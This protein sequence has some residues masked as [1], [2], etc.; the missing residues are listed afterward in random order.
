MVQP[1]NAKNCAA[2]IIKILENHGVTHVFGVPGAKIDSLFIA[3]KHSKI[4]LVLCRHEQNAAFMA[5]AFGRLTGT[6]GVCIATSGPG[7]TNLTTGLATATSEGDPVLAIGGEVPLDE[8]LKKT[9]QSL[10]AVDLMK[11]VTKFSAEVVTAHQL[12]EIIGNAI[13]V[14]ES[15]RPGAVFV[16]LPKDVGLSDFDGDATA[17]WGKKIPQGPC[18]DLAI[19]DAAKALHASKRPIAI[20][21][22][23]SSSKTCSEALIE[24]LKKTQIPYISTFQG[25]G[26]WV[27]KQ[28]ASIYAGRIGLFRNQ[29]ADKLLEQADL[30]ITIGYDAIEYDPAIWNANNTRPMICIDTIRADQDNSFIPTAEL[31]GDIGH[32]LTL[33]SDAVSINMIDIDSDYIAAAQQAFQ[34]VQSTIAEGKAMDNFP[35]QPLRLV[36]ELQ[37]QMTDATHVALDVGSNYIWTNRYGVTHHAR[38]VLVSNGQ[39]TLGVSVPWAI[40]LSLLYPDQRVLSVSGDGGFLF[41]SMELETAVRVGAKF[42]HVIWDSHS[43]DMVAFQEMA[44]YGE[45]AGVEL[46]GYDVVKMAESFGCKGYSIKSAN[47][48]PHVFEEAFK[49]EVP[50]LI[51]VPVDYSLNA[52]LMEDIHQSFIN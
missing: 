39:Q 37:K 24:F 7:I 3:L 29:P 40:A 2:A 27:E 22:M 52:R 18:S 42:V 4:K 8:R 36:Y 32:S 14:A 23:Q 12:A 33:L 31:I 35:V 30:V 43:Y 13:R 17:S 11:A 46:G 15:G 21:G 6:I 25:A 38:Q 10:D 48:L 20:L 41:S 34:E 26:A 5:A 1:Y 50:V 44:H 49:A 45:S 16:S 19:A 51:H 9:H 28:G 47:E